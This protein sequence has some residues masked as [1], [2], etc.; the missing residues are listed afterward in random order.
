MGLSERRK[1]S[2]AESEFVTI[3][4]AVDPMA[5]KV[6][7]SGAVEGYEGDVIGLGLCWSVKRRK[8]L[9][10]T[11]EKWLGG[12]D[13]LACREDRGQWYVYMPLRTLLELLQERGEAS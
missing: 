3:L 13:A 4:K 6:P 10:V 2:R 11:W 7:L 5:R 9:P 1:G 12:M 8:K